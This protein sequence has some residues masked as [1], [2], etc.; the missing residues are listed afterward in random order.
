MTPPEL[1]PSNHDA[2][3]FESNP[4]PPL[5]QTSPESRPD[6]RPVTMLLR[7]GI[8]K[9]DC[10]AVQVALGARMARMRKNAVAVIRAHGRNPWS[11]K[12]T[13]Q[14]ETRM[15]RS[16]NHFSLNVSADGD[17]HG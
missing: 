2:C 10:L 5:S 14:N 6:A 16:A 7:L 4:P 11:F 1:D 3:S 17:T 9:A 12:K 15:A 8:A 13:N